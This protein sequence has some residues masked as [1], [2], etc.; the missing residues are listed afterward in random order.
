MLDDANRGFLAQ[1]AKAGTPPIHE[2]TPELARQ[3]GAAMVELLGPGP[4]MA[5]VENLAIEAADGDPINLRVLVP[6]GP[7]RG[8]IVYLHGGGW[9]LGALDQS[10]TLARRLAE[11]TSCAV[12]LVDYRL[13]PEH[14]YP[15]SVEDAWTTMALVEAAFESSAKPATALRGHP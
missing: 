7:V 5:R 6:G 14:R 15:T 8:I 4:D 9:V 10:D 1:L 2:L 12:V 11:R 3:A 13:A